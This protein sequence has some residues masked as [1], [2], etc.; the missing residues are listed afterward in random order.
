MDSGNA[1]VNCEFGY[2]PLRGVCSNMD[3][4][5]STHLLESSY[6]YHLMVCQFKFKRQ[7]G[8][9]ISYG[10]GSYRHLCH[11]NKTLRPFVIFEIYSN[12]VGQTQWE[13]G[14]FHQHIALLLPGF[15]IN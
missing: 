12:D 9:V 15:W 14:V 10:W 6:R 3:A 1:I 7:C 2:F 5:T 13:Y 11:H 4:A 8:P